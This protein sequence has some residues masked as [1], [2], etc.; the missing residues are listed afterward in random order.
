MREV[1][2]RVPQSSDRMLIALQFW[3]GD[4]KPAYELAR[5]LA[6]IEPEH[7]KRADFLLISRFDTPIDSHV[8]KHVS[9]KFDTYHLRCRR[10][11]VGHPCGCNELWFGVWEWIAGRQSRGVCYKMAF[12]CEGDGAPVT[13]DWISRMHMAWDKAQPANVVGAY[14]GDHINGNALFSCH[15]AFVTYLTRRVVSVSKNAGWDRV[16]WRNFQQWGAKGVEEI[17]SYWQTPTMN[18]EWFEAEAASGAVWIHG[19]KDASLHQQSR[20]RLISS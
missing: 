7:Q 5:L 11:G 17:R 18:P 4:A 15:P 20:K 3:N 2:F 14:L 13:R 12:T 16:L 1:K 10:Q 6:D 9:R 19:V 8:V